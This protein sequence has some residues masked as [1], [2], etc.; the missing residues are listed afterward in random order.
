MRGPLFVSGYPRSGTTLLRALLGAHSR[1]AMV[2]EPEL[3]LGMMTAGLQPRFGIDA[4]ARRDLL[5]ILDDI[6]ICRRHLATLPPEVLRQ[7][8]DAP[9]ELTFK[10]A[11][12]MLLPKPA[13][14]V[15][16]GS[17]SLSDAFYIPAIEELYPRMLFV[18]IV[19]DPRAAILSLYRKQYQTS[20]HDTPSFTPDNVRFIMFEALRWQAWVAAASAGSRGLAQDSYIGIRFEDLV[21]D[22][23]REAGAICSALGLEYEAEMLEPENRRN[24]PV[25]SSEG[26]FAHA[27]L[28]DA[29]EVGRAS[30]GEEMP[31]WC[32]LIISRYAG[33]EMSE[34]GYPNVAPALG[35]MEKAKVNAACRMWQAGVQERLERFMR[36]RGCG[37][38]A[39]SDFVD[40][41]RLGGRRH[42]HTG[43]IARPA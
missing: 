38:R 43:A 14:D 41:G 26:A 31:R 15:V 8:R 19:R 39:G 27:R 40:A 10:Q 30:A 13:G 22:P 12:E 24:D 21:S 35:V 29:V 18:N 9:H 5:C 4:A 32:S 16:W 17:K 34:W 2:N 25:L 28:R 7:F 23:Q 11:F 37:S 42:S 20:A 33:E 6:G 3:L 1:I 36:S